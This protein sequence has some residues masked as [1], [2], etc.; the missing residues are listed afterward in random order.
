MGQKLT[1]NKNKVPKGE[2]GNV[3]SYYNINICIY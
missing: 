2:E 1:S 3:M